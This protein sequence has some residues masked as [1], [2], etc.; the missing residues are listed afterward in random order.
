MNGTWT[1]R[2]LDL[3]HH[4][5]GRANEVAVEREGQIAEGYHDT[6]CVADQ[7][8]VEVVGL[9]NAKLARGNDLLPAP[10]VVREEHEDRKAVVD[11]PER[12]LEEVEL[13]L[14]DVAHLYYRHRLV[15]RVEQVKEL[16]R[17]RVDALEVDQERRRSDGVRLRGSETELEP[18]LFS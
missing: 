16:V 8:D 14:V 17:Q 12:A 1:S 3:P 6:N 5:I 7:L 10:A 13:E 15:D 9:R 18:K 4:S 2:H 11:H